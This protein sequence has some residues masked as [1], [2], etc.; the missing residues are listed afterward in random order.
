MRQKY[1]PN[2][3]IE[4]REMN[5]GEGESGA[6]AETVYRPLTKEEL[7]T[8]QERRGEIFEEL[9]E[10]DASALFDLPEK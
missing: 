7:K 8:A 10:M 4:A 1:K 2:P 9:D 5:E 3:N 6:S